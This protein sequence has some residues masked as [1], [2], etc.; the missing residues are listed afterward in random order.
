LKLVGTEFLAGRGHWGIV[1][2]RR[3]KFCPATGDPH[4]G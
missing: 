2:R 4:R 1:L 3:P